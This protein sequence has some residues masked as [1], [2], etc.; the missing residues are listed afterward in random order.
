[1]GRKTLPCS[2]GIETAFTTLIAHS[3]NVERHCPVPK[4]L[5]PVR[6]SFLKS[7]QRRKTLPCSKG[8]ETEDVE[9]NEWI[10]MGRK[11]LPCSKGIETFPVVSISNIIPG[12]KTL[13]C[14]KGIKIKFLLLS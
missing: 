12:R 14:S 6:C 2:K 11:T 13:P 7:T 5:K 10:Y 1:M 8:I 9:L 4:G 3:V